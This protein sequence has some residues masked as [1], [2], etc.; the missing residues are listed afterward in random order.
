MTAHQQRESAHLLLTGISDIS[1]AGDSF[2]LRLSLV[3]RG[4]WLRPWR[5]L[6]DE[7]GSSS[8]TVPGWCWPN[9]M[10]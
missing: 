6:M 1:W 5:Q 8:L 7:W 10:L 2:V 3:H 9:I 4:R